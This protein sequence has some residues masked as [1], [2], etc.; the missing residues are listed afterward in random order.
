MA[1]IDADLDRLA[2][3]AP[4][5]LCDLWA[6]R[7]DPIV[8]ALPPQLLRRMLA[9]RLQEKRFGVLPAMVARELSRVVDTDDVVPTRP[10][11]V[12]IRPGT[13]LLREWNGRT[14]SVIAADN[15]F[16]WEDKHYLSLSAVA[17]AVT[18]AAW[19]GP[20][21]FGLVAR[22]DAKASSHG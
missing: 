16:V 6:A 5:E 17:R 1:R 8:P 12:V 13:R 10:E 20:R 2:A 4:G 15:G 21:F 11:P 19:S 18:G 3:I 7:I 14:I 22:S 9:Q